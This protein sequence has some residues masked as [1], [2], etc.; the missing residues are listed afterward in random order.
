MTRTLQQVIDNIEPF[1]DLEEAH[2][3][4]ALAWIASGSP[5]YRTAKPATPPKHLVAYCALVDPLRRSV[6]LV[7]HRDA[8]LWLLTGGHVDPGEDPAAAAQRELRE[9][10]ALSPTFVRG[11]DAAPL[12]ITCTVTEGV[13]AG[14]TDVSL[15]YVFAGS[16]TDELQP[17]PG[18]FVDSRW[19]PMDE[20]RHG[21][22]T[23]FDPNL[24][25]FTTKLLRYWDSQLETG[26]P[27]RNQTPCRE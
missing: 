12:F 22:D 14:H 3:E 2:R 15:W 10:L 23:R 21:E 20:V 18:E 13:S 17:D 16:E 7:D 9:E 19:W 4:D 26:V 24:P 8:G 25:R 11:L 5:I 27:E 1:D 6:L